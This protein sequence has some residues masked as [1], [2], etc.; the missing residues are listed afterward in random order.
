[1]KNENLILLFL[2][3]FLNMNIQPIWKEWRKKLEFKY[4][5]IN[6]NC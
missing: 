1:M 5:A 6:L 4:R 3:I 2:I